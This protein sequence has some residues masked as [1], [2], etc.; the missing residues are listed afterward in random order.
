MFVRTLLL[1]SLSVCF[2]LAVPAALAQVIIE[3]VQIT[4]LDKRRDDLL[5]E[6]IEASLSLFDVLG[7]EQSPS[8]LD[9]L[10]TQAQRQTRQALE[11][12]GYYNPNISLQVPPQS[13]RVRVR[14]HV[15]KG[16]AARVRRSEVV[17]TGPA[18]RDRYLQQDLRDFRPQEGE[19]FNH[20]SYEESKLTIS[21]RLSERGYFDADFTQR[22]VEITRADNAADLFL[23]WDSGRR[24]NMGRIRFHQD[25]FTAN[26]F[27]PLVYWEEGSYWHSGK[28]ER[29]RDSLNRL[30]YFGVID[31]QPDP[32]NAYGDG[33][34]PVDIYLTPAKRTIYS[35]GISYGTESGPG[36]RAGMERRYI[37]TKGHKLDVQAEEARRRRS[38]IVT[39][40]IPEFDWLDGWYTL[41]LSR[42]EESIR[43]I[44]LIN[45]RWVIGRSGKL[46]DY[47][48]VIFSIHT[49]RERWRYGS[50]GQFSGDY[51]LANVVY[52][53]F[54]ADYRDVDDPLFPRDG[55]I[56]NITFR[57]GVEHGG[58]NTNF[59]QGNVMLRWFFPLLEND[60]FI[61]RN[62]IGSTWTGRL[63]AMP[64]SLRY[65]AGGDLSVRGYGYREIGPRTAAPDRFAMGA[66]NLLTGSM[67]Y[68]HYFRSGPWGMALFVDTGSAFDY[69]IILRS[70]IGLGLRWQSPLGPV[71][72]D[73]A[74]GLDTPDSPIQIYLNIG[75]ER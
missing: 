57:A 26:L 44:D 45:N 50:G 61:L 52:P 51:Q 64:P 31:M 59:L 55:F 13:G 6:N 53:K 39:Y 15:D 69:D 21:R 14:V 25:Y 19:I 29:L 9:Y 49:L 5:I 75:A 58:D 20:S 63:I 18:A 65:F 22:R 33:L 12:F 68:E 43:Y 73:I 40:K 37:N 41:S 60:R 7:Q 34:V 28:L 2:L 36:V 17:I 47:W 66:R 4:G 56:S 32:D 74:R 24:Y 10:L 42:Y 71:R 11:P 23:S 62:E 35:A 16:Q 3:K 27:D 46:N 1:F 54:N 30:D 8:R 38:Q 70:G 67:E 72:I 48:N